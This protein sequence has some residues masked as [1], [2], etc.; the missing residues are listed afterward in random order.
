MATSAKRL[1]AMAEH[2]GWHTDALALPRTAVTP[3]GASGGR[4]LGT[5]IHDLRRNGGGFAR[6]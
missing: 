4:I 1:A 5:M 3:V 2:Y 6:G